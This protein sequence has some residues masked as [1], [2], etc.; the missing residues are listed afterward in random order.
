M[1]AN[2]T[3]R[4]PLKGGGFALVDADV[5]PLLSRYR[6]KL[7]HHGYPIR[8]DVGIR[9]NG[10]RAITY[11]HHMVLPKR[12]DCYVDHWN[13][14]PLDARRANLRYA[15]NS[16]NQ[17]NRRKVQGAVPIK[18]VTVHKQTGKYQAQ[19]KCGGK[20]HY[21]GLHD[22]PIEAGRAYYAAALEQFGEYA[23]SNL[24]PEIVA[25]IEAE[26]RQKKQRKAA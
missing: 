19:V 24:P 7:D 2:R 22:D 14:D 1:P 15:S 23:W 10:K 21:L 9:A 20:S 6:W 13:G 18:G 16:Q 11:L 25:A 5:F 3:R 17:A 26:D 12:K 4:L 8:D